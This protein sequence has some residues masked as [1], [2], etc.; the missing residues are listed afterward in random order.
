MLVFAL[1]TVLVF[2]IRRSCGQCSSDSITITVDPNGFHAPRNVE[3]VHYFATNVNGATTVSLL[4][5]QDSGASNLLSGDQISFTSP[6]QNV[7]GRLRRVLLQQAGVSP[8]GNN[9]VPI[10][11]IPLDFGVLPRGK[12]V[13]FNPITGV[14]TLSSIV[15][16]INIAGAIP[17]M[18]AS[19]FNQTWFNSNTPGGCASCTTTMENY[20]STCS[21]NKVSISNTLGNNTVI[22]FTAP[23]YAMPASGRTVYSGLPYNTTLQC[24]AIEPYAMQEWAQFLYSKL[25]GS[26]LTI[27]KYQRRIVVM[28]FNNCNAYGFGSQG[29]VGAYCYSWIRGDRVNF[30]NTFFHE[31]SHTLNMQHSQSCIWQYG[32]CSCVMGCSSDRGCPNAPNSIRAGWSTP[33]ASLWENNFT[34]GKWYNYSIPAVEVSSVNAV[35]IFPNWTTPNWGGNSLPAYYL[36]MKINK[37]YDETIST[38]YTGQLSVHLTNATNIND[39]YMPLL[40]GDGTGNQPGDQCLGSGLTLGGKVNDTVTY[41]IIS[42]TGFN[43]TAASTSVCRYTETVETNCHDGLDNDCN[44]LVDSQDPACGGGGTCGNG[45]CQAPE[46]PLTCPADCSHTCG[47]AYGCAAPLNPANCPQSCP[48]VCGDGYCVGSETVFSCPQDCPGTCGDGVCNSYFGES[49]STCPQDCPGA[50]GDGICNTFFETCTNC[51]SDCSRTLHCPAQSPPSPPPMKS[52]PPSLSPPPSPPPPS[53]PPPPP[54]SSPPHP[55][56]P[57]HPHPKVKMSKPLKKRK[58]P[59]PTPPPIQAKKKS[60]RALQDQDVFSGLPLPHSVTIAIPE[61]RALLQA[62]SGYYMQPRMSFISPDGGLAPQEVMAQVQGFASQ[63]HTPRRVL[64]GGVCPEGDSSIDIVVKPEVHRGA[65]VPFPNSRSH[66]RL[67]EMGVLPKKTIEQQSV[68]GDGVC[69]GNED[70]LSCGRDCCPSGSCGDG[71]C[72]AWLGE[73]CETCPEDCHGNLEEEGSSADLYCCGAY[74]G[75]GDERCFADNAVCQMTCMSPP[76]RPHARF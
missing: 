10:I 73:N 26:N 62:A 71:K 47:D 76:D 35:R 23:Q 1:Y 30:L 38:T 18:T 22:D 70:V 54:H 48:P 57:P 69:N 59:P 20:V 15:F 60:T 21:Y 12:P 40:I 28:S 56:H 74:V 65:G 3:G 32:D 45:V 55:P 67:M 4:A 50:C 5:I 63:E 14:Q 6:C 31:L 64:L 37:G 39:P 66:R 25:T 16:L 13:D 52:P 43:G 7:S 41:L 61:R 42:Y 58:P 2:F 46:N 75:C 72:H 29:C 49:L 51:Y 68:C 53:P 44:G 8:D 9:D 19:A 36:S 11:T 27:S 24:G 17:P 33:I 34:A